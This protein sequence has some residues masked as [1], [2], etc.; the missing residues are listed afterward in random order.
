M[1][2]SAANI[3]G[4]LF[5]CL[6]VLMA[7]T[8]VSAIKHM[9]FQTITSP[10]ELRLSDDRFPESVVVSFVAFFF[11]RHLVFVGG[12]SDVCFSAGFD[13]VKMFSEFVTC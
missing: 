1:M 4:Y 11:R 9:T 3:P 2:V 5:C 10:F 12:F 8:T 6:G 7:L 13:M